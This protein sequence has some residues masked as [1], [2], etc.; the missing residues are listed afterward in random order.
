M[1]D[2][3][4]NTVSKNHIYGLDG[5]RAIAII[6]VTLFHMFPDTIQGGY[7]GTSLFFVL[8]GYLMAVTTERSV[9]GGSF[10]VLSY[11]GKRVKRIYPALLLVL[12]ITVGVYWLIDSEAL[13]GIRPEMLSIVGGYDN[14]WQIAQNADYFSRIANASPFTHLWFLSIEMQF[15]LVWPLV[16]MLVY[17]VLA[18]KKDSKAGLVFLALVTLASAVFS[19][20][21]YQPGSDV[22]RIY[23]GTDTRLYA[24]TFG[25]CLG[26]AES[27][28]CLP[29]IRKE[30]VGKVAGPLLLTMLVLIGIA[31]VFMNGQIDFT[32]RGGMILMTLLF[33]VLIVLTTDRRVRIGKILE[34]SPLTWL[35]KRSY[36]LYLWQY[37]V[38]FLFMNK[39]WVD[40]YPWLYLVEGVALVVLAAFL[41]FVTEGLFSLFR[42]EAEGRGR[43]T[44]RRVAFHLSSVLCLIAVIFGVVGTV[45]AGT[46][47]PGK[48]DELAAHLEEQQQFLEE[49]ERMDEAA[50]EEGGAA[51]EKAAE[52]EE[53]EE[54]EAID[55]GK[56][57]KLKYG[58]PALTNAAPASKKRVFLI[59]DSILESAAR[60]V[61]NELP[62]ARISARQNRQVAEAIDIIKEAKREGKI[63]KSV[64]IALGT[65]GR[66]LM[67]TAEEIVELLGDDV[68]IFW[69]NLFGRTVTWRREAN[70]NLEELAEEH[71]NFS[72]I[73]WYSLI[74]D[75]GDRWLW[76]D[77]EH[78]NLEGEK[79]YAR[80]IRE[81]I[82]AVMYNRKVEE[83][84]KKAA[85]KKKDT[86][87]GEAA[88]TEATSAE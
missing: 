86:N 27:H 48:M 14:W 82:D 16:V 78:P 11:Y 22:T 75:N 80:L 17:R 34:A 23:Y 88:G 20:I 73:D 81:S 47:K 25:V 41:H 3:P 7:L 51:S 19:L 42:R 33:G 72:V 21:L 84:Q 67:P 52:L 79:I 2:K 1:M 39:G 68:S 53:K 35:G 40:E 56:P 18:R 50:T 70:G 32:Y 43:S 57:P 9:S 44:G 65:N 12:L 87:A 13:G 62:G 37:P 26:W 71:P 77:G 59:G 30:S 54:E 55:V 58:D 60:A 46:E 66:I 5:L 63:K 4:M 49:M 85:E 61:L 38:I 76:P 64:V 83:A 24:L 36:E 8:T 74:K 29:K 28:R 31:Y 15:Y 69:V 10:K 6:G 45:T